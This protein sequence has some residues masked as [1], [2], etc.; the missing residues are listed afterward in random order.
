MGS[1][2]FIQLEIWGM[3]FVRLAD[4][5][6]G[7]SFKLS[8][9]I[10]S[11]IMLVIS[12]TAFVI[13]NAVTQALLYEL[14]SQS[15]EEI[16]LLGDILKKDGSQELVKVLNGLNNT[17]V[18]KERI[19]GLFNHLDQPI[20]GNISVAPDFVGWKKTVLS[21]TGIH[22]DK[23]SQHQYHTRI[24]ELDGYT[25]VVARSDTLIA[26]VQKKLLMWLIIGA[27]VISLTSLTLGVLSSADSARKIKHM[28]RVLKQ[29][30]DGSTEARVE[31]SQQPHPDQLDQ[32]GVKINYHLSKLS[33][34]ITGIKST[35]SAVAH[36]LK[37]PLSHIQISLFDALEQS[38]K[39]QNPAP[40]IEAAID[41]VKAINTTFDTILRIS[42]INAQLDKS[43]FQ[44][45]DLKLTVEKI[46]ELF[47]PV[48]A[49]IGNQITLSLEAKPPASTQMFGDA[50]MIEQ[51]LVNLLRNIQVHCPQGTLVTIN[52][53]PKAG[54]LTLEVQ[55]NGP[56][57]P[58]DEI[59][60]VLKP[61]HRVD[62]ARTE[63]GNGLGLTLIS[64]I[65]HH[66]S[67]K[68]SLHNRS[69]GLSV[70]IDFPLPK[71]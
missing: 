67:A 17:Y 27:I 33:E 37:T 57:I 12:L 61:F 47:E 50:S 32:L 69:P 13:Y 71:A 38:E 59:D 18:P 35:A 15:E 5:I 43:H 22:P 51:L 16:A 36:D 64:A 60:K 25:L 53:N 3:L 10:T 49:D 24:I 63:S 26:A 70:S 29:V 6:P 68:V 44:W 2:S 54:S 31:I 4:I 7:S 9:K 39:G 14:S 21:I 23:E 19:V 52:L 56:G 40:T 65:A 58:Q 46:S 62:K 11:L 28:D 34:L 20:A 1:N 30:A 8:L 66:H 55:D 42:R 41:E 45:F 48:Y